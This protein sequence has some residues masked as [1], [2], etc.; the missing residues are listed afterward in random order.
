[1]L[2]NKINQKN[3]I[4]KEINKLNKQLNELRAYMRD[5]AYL[6]IL[7]MYYNTAPE[8]KASVKC[9]MQA[10]I[11]IISKDKYN[12]LN[13]SEEIKIAEDELKF[14][15]NWLQEAQDDYSENKRNK[16]RQDK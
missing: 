16:D 4:D 6:K 9:G 12:K 7:N 14:Y 10:A 2:N 13:L 1:M 15:P 8:F 11:N 5:D 3:E